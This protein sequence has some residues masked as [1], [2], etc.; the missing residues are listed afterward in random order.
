MKNIILISSFFFIASCRPSIDVDLVRE[1]NRFESILIKGV[2]IFDGRSE[3]IIRRKDVLIKNGRIADIADHIPP[4]KK[5]HQIDG[6]SKTLMPGLVDAHVHLSG[7]GAVPWKNQRANEEYNLQAYL[8]AGITTVYD[9]G[10]LRK[11]IHDLG[12]K[13]KNGEISG[14]TIYNTHIPITVKNSHPIPLTKLMLP[15]PM[16]GL[17]NTLSPTIDQTDQAEKIISDYVTEKVDYVKIVCDQ[18]PPGSPQMS[19][20][21]LKALIEAS[22]SIG[23]KVFVHVGSPDNALDAIRAGADVLAHGIWRGQLSPDQADSIAASKIPIIYTISGF[24]NVASIYNGV[25][26]P[27]QWDKQLVL[28]DVLEPVAGENGK[29]VRHEKVINEFFADVHAHSKIWAHNFKLLYQKNAKILVGTDSNLPGTYAGSTYYQELD[30]LKSFGM[31]NYELLKAATYLN[32]IAFLSQPD[33]G[34]IEVGK[35]AD[36]LLL[37]GNPLE[38]IQHVKNPSKIF[39]GGRIYSRSKV[40]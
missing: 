13:V 14:P 22:H 4:Q 9:L 37:N 20:D 1:E 16:S 17:V 24:S 40:D 25:F 32:S 2:D 35:K 33:F 34:L 19:F 10:G 26:E 7:S 28:N 30:M 5:Y 15:W 39:A 12:L 3:D 31:T 38:D 29:Q 18:I 36:L 11:N 8:Y 6:A 27:S 21:Q 23:K